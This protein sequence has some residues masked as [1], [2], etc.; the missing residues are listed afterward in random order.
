MCVTHRADE[1]IVPAW[2]WRSESGWQPYNKEM[3]KRLEKARLKGKTVVR[4]DKQRLVDLANMVQKNES[5]GTH[6]RG[7]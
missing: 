1:M 2:H 3:C 5:S 4:I 6:R 7:E